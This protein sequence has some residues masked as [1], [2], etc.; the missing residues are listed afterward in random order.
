MTSQLIEAF[1]PLVS[2]SS[3]E[4]R[5]VCCHGDTVQMIQS[6]QLCWNVCIGAKTKSGM[7][8]IPSSHFSF[9]VCLLLILK[10]LHAKIHPMRIRLLTSITKWLTFSHNSIALRSINEVR[11]FQG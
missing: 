1:H 11:D 8:T 3:L 6:N 2:K 9:S 7:F 4:N 5:S 10:Q